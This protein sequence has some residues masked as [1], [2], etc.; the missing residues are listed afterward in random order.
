MMEPEHYNMGAA[1]KP[2]NPEAVAKAFSTLIAHVRASDKDQAALL[3]G[4]HYPFLSRDD[5]RALA[6]WLEWRVY[7][8]RNLS[9]KIRDRLRQ[10]LEVHQMLDGYEYRRQDVRKDRRRLHALAARGALPARRD[11]R[12]DEA[13]RKTV[14][15]PT[16]F[17][18]VKQ[19]MKQK[20]N[21][22]DAH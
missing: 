1:E 17:E 19:L 8:G 10:T 3:L 20:R 7:K 14:A 6:K 21:R 11:E 22:A 9:K 15:A 4:Y 2:L 18:L 16:Q 5:R 12:P 13:D